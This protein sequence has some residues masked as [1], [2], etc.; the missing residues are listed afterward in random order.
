MALAISQN[1]VPATTPVI[2]LPMVSVGWSRFFTVAG[3]VTFALALWPAVG[4]LVL[5]GDDL[6]LSTE[7]DAMVL[8]MGFI[9]FLAFSRLPRMMLN[10]AAQLGADT[11]QAALADDTRAP[12]LYL[13]SFE[14][15]QWDEMSYM[16]T[17]ASDETRL[18]TALASFGPVLAIGRPG[19]RL[20]H[21]GAA[22][23][24]V[25]Q[26][27]WQDVVRRI[28]PMTGLVVVRAGGT[29]GLGWELALIRE[30]LTPDK[31][32]LWV[33]KDCVQAE[34]F[35]VAHEAMKVDLPADLHGHAIITFDDEWK[36]KPL[37]ARKGGPD[38][39]S[40]PSPFDSFCTEAR[41]L[42][43]ATASHTGGVD[44]STPLRQFLAG[45]QVGTVPSPRF[46][47][48]PAAWLGAGL[49]LFLLWYIPGDRLENLLLLDHRWR[50]LGICLEGALVLMYALLFAFN[51]YYARPS[52][53]EWPSVLIFLAVLAI[54]LGFVGLRFGPGQQVEA[55]RVVVTDPYLHVGAA[56]WVNNAV[57][58]DGTRKL[59][60]LWDETSWSRCMAPVRSLV[61][62]KLVDSKNGNAFL[63][64]PGFD[65]S[66]ACK[67][68]LAELT[69][70]TEVEIL[71]PTA[72]CGVGSEILIGLNMN[73]VKVLDGKY[74]GTIG[75]I[76]SDRLSP[77]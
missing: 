46:Y 64:G 2:E 15:D 17:S 11:A 77:I 75:C 66:G 67:E 3:Y 54:D 26:T 70:D 16:Q 33:P 28:A 13:R 51:G 30:V 62:S 72:D 74:A 42:P 63:T 22:R 9:F 21:I 61:D 47:L 49:W 68:H 44:S 39:F 60:P 8:L 20:G 73:R 52:R 76:R 29:P 24:Y 40:S 69:Q 6:G 7:L 55:Q 31:V 37:Y 48:H 65:A 53:R 38:A 1:R 4:T 19:D 5:L 32:A 71:D 12:I 14:A 36:A 27:E 45:L 10:M 18:V 23:L 58:V 41:Q 56:R 43:V 50:W 35:W 57:G 25:G 59:T 34:F